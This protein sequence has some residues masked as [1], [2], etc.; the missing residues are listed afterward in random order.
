LDG[1]FEPSIDGAEIVLPE[2]SSPLRFDIGA[3]MPN[4]RFRSICIAA[5]SA[6]LASTGC[7]TT[8]RMDANFD[9]D[10]VGALPSGA[11]PPTPP[12]D[13]LTWTVRQP[14]TST[15]VMDPAG[16][17]SVRVMPLPPFVV[18]PDEAHLALI[19]TT[20][21][22]TAKPPRKLRGSMRLGL[23]QLGRI[24]IGF[25]PTPSDA[26]GSLIAGIEL[27]NFLGKT[28]AAPPDGQI[29]LLRSFVLPPG[30]ALLVVSSAG[31]IG[32]VKSGALT[33]I[34]WIIDQAAGSFS[35]SGENGAT[36]SF[37]LP[38]RPIEQ[39]RIYVWMEQPQSGTALIIDDLFAEE[40]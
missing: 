26:Q 1:F 10:T 25:E 35:A 21:P 18:S 39:L 20:E 3:T 31:N 22:L 4:S 32:S 9:S 23:S 7:A 27:G 19:A 37:Q 11:P 38:P 34:S 33:R 30:N 16:G 13:G 36:A 17:N 15:V 2:V 12:A 14:L 28:R 24:I 6:T 5:L 8:V 29:D 40:F